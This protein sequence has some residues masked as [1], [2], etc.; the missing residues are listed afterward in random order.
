[1]TEEMFKQSLL[2]SHINKENSQKILIY[3]LKNELT[4][5]QKLLNEERLNKLKLVHQEEKELNII[6]YL[7]H[8]LKKETKKEV[9][10]EYNKK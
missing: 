9:Q 2:D 6:D 5:V 4:E 3:F 7:I 8:V 1:M 10:N